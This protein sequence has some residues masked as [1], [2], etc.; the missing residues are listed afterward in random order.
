MATAKELRVWANTIRQWAVKIDDTQTATQAADL[1]VVLD[2]LAARKE[3]SDRQL[4]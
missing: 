4:V 3:V 2:G 1:A